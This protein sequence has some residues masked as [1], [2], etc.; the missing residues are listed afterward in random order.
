[1]ANIPTRDLC[2]WD[3][4]NSGKNWHSHKVTDNE[5]EQVFQNAPIIRLTDPKHSLEERRDAILG[6]TDSGRLLFISYTMRGTK[7]RVISARDMN[8]KERNQYEQETERT[9]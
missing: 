6:K 3:A 2:D 5:A 8:R 4:G 9:A 7:Y 1:M